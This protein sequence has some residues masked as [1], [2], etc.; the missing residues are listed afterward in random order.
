MTKAVLDETRLLGDYKLIKQI[1]Q[2]S[3]GAV[4]AAE[5]RFTKKQYVIKILPEELANDRGFLQRFE[6]EI[7]SLA[8]LEH[9]H[10]VKMK[11]VSFSQGLYFLISECVVDKLGESTNLWQYFTGN[12]RALSEEEIMQIATQVASA[13]DY[14]HNTKKIVHRALKFNNILIGSDVTGALRVAISDFGLSKIIGLGSCLTRSFKAVAEAL[15]I[16]SAVPHAKIG[17]DRYPVPA[18]EA[19][20]LTPL[21]QSFLQN[22]AFLAPE[23]KRLDATSS[24]KVDI[25][26]FGVLIYVLLMNEFPEGIFP[27]P[28]TR[29]RIDRGSTG[30][31]FD[32]IVTECLKQNPDDR[33]KSLE[34][35]LLRAS[36]NTKSGNTKNASLN[37]EPI[38]ELLEK[39]MEAVIADVPTDKKGLQF[40][41]FGIQIRE[42]EV[43]ETSCLPRIDRAVKEYQPEK[44]EVRTIQPHRTEMVVIGGDSYYRGSNH[45]CRDEMPRHRITLA[46]FAL[47]IHPVTNEQFVCFMDM[48]GEEKDTQNHDIIR[49]RDSRIKRSSGRFLI[50]PGYAKHP[51]VGVTWYGAVAY[52]TWVGK[53]LPT[54]AEWET[55][56]C[57][58]LE[59]P[60]YPTGETIEKTQANFFSSD[61]T[62]VMSY[63]SNQYGLYDIVG[64][65]YEWCQDWYEYAY[66]EISSLEPDYPKGPLQGVYRV[67][68]GGCW[69]S[70]KEDLRC[71]KRHRNNPGASNGTYGFR[72]AADVID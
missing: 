49:L 18:A 56:C 63:P 52:A 69:K 22:F 37:T 1:G 54:E 28:S 64:N 3:L 42:K 21:H 25:Y 57:G 34:E 70:L 68:R 45:G 27:L 16:A 33:P 7:A 29:T 26:A 51:V 53:R 17:Q 10:I 66:Y 35:L 11:T 14:A 61:T 12:A 58:G 65:V 50:E 62:A 60:M 59:N 13:L 40:D 6:D 30:V 15:S 38:A 9:P 55:A 5:H 2:G 32:L 44:K 36:G 41:L 47:D 24:E 48:I 39:K 46:P 72:C 67:L 19:Q 20:K 8:T 43:G 71:S 23:Q 31:D 4:F